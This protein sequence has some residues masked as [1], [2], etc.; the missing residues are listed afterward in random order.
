MTRLFTILSLLC[1]FAMK[2]NA[3]SST[4][5][6]Q[7]VDISLT[8]VIT[9]KFVSTGSTTG[10]TVSMPISTISQY[11]SGVTSSAQQL[12]AASTKPFSI[13]VRT[14]AANFTYTGS[15]TTGTTMAVSSR[16]KLIVSANSTGGSIASPF[17]STTYQTLT[18]T[19]Q[20]LIT[21][22]TTGNN[23]TFSITYQAIP[24]LSFPAGTYTTSVIY[25]AT[26]Q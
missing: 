22:C 14:N 6:T 23:K 5:E 12:I 25:T 16:L 3:Q 13:T 1:L 17:S 11:T 8:N 26:Q 20:N 15:Y 21:N 18:S 10:S 19:N 9:L 7:Q 24:G 2:A 4:V